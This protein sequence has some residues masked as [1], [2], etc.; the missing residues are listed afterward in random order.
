MP[1]STKPASP[2]HVKRVYAAAAESDGARVLVDRLWPRGIAKDK[3]RIELWLKE[4]APSDALRHRVH[5]DPGAWDSFVADYAAELQG[6]PADSAVTQL[7]EMIARGPVTLLYAARDE[8]R[9]NAVA[10]K[11]WL[12]KT[13]RKSRA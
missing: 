10:L 12:E 4:I 11:A 3:A 5:R 6:P 9:N 8:T 7:R 2:L 13:S 1:T